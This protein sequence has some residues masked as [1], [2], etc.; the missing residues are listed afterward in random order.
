MKPAIEAFSIP[1]GFNPYRV[2]KFVATSLP[3]FLP[4]R[5]LSLFQSLSGF[6]VRCNPG[7]ASTLPLEAFWFQSLSGFQVRCNLFL[8]CT[9]RRI[10]SVSIPIGFSSSLQPIPEGWRVS[11]DHGFNPY[12]VFKFVAT[13]ASC[14]RSIDWSKFQSLSGFQV[15][16]NLGEVEHVR[17][18]LDV[19]IP[20]GFSSSLQPRRCWL[21]RFRL[22]RVSIPIGF[23]SSLQPVVEVVSRPARYSFNPYRVFK[24]VATRD[25][26]ANRG[27]YDLVSIPIGF[28]SSLQPK[29]RSHMNSRPAWFQSLSGFQVRCNARTG[30][31]GEGYGNCFNPYRV[32]KFVATV[33]LVAPSSLISKFQSLSGF[34]VR[35]NIFIK[36]VFPIRCIVS[37]PIG[38]SSSLQRYTMPQ[39]SGS[40][41]GFNPYRVFKFVATAWI[42]RSKDTYHRFQSLSGFQ[43]RCNLHLG[44]RRHRNRPVSIP[45]G[46]S[47][48]LQ[49]NLAKA[50]GERFAGFQS[51]SGFQVRCN[52]NGRLDTPFDIRFVSIP[53]GFSSSLQHSWNS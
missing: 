26:V 4:L 46:F 45:I 36:Q 13:L 14:Y 52:S 3:F 11:Q 10:E 20:I 23:S 15:R 50:T 34:Q 47:S 53:I 39:R 17:V 18:V 1:R 29:E 27:E 35:C 51:L 44:E 2:F 9:V 31:Q 7:I 22:S 25:P 40:G 16:C 33:N 28:S 48:S 5:G 8:A 19:S 38:F 12:R 24:F 49:P 30:L 21:R 37:I 32:F 6:Q 43:V 41:E 42:A